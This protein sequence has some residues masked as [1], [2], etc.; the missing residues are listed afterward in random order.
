M[1][2]QL[3]ALLEQGRYAELLSLL[4]QTAS[5]EPGNATVGSDDADQADA[6]QVDAQVIALKC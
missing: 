6:H 1:G 4:G 3:A 5:G 2:G